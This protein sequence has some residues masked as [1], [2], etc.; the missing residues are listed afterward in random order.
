MVFSLPVLAQTA[1]PEPLVAHRIAPR[2]VRIS[3]TDRCDMAC[4]YCRPSM[5]DGYVA[6]EERL[7]E[8][9]WDTLLSSLISQGIRRVRIT[10]GEP[11]L[12]RGLL[13][14]VA[15]IRALELDDLALTTNA[16]RLE[17][18][19]QPLRDAGLDRMNISLDSLD[20]QRFA[21]MTR[22]GNLAQVLAG[23][24]A[25]QRAGFTDLKTNTVVLADHNDDELVAITEWAWHKNMTPRFIEVMGVGEGAH[26]FRTHAVGY[27]RM[28]R[29]LAHL[30]SDDE[31]RTEKDRGPAKY[32]RSRD[33]AHRVGFITGTTHTYCDEC[34]RLRVSSTGTLRAC[35]ARNEG[36]DVSEAARM[37][38]S[39]ALSEGLA[40]A[41]RMKPDANFK[42]C[43]EESAAAVSMRATGG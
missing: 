41:W 7:D 42:G 8:S 40:E 1:T 17:A 5:H 13:P 3:L 23:I 29:A 18:L 38:D 32:A 24:D 22:G 12:Y 26:L 28:R 39:R 15:R 27:T 33:G 20:P 4:I 6:A 34:D 37:G 35:L 21:A 11:L 14:L 9:A 16:S 43:T 2:S 25:A 36:V 30:L 31:A 10:G 19:A